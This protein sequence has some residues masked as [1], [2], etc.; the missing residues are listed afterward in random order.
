MRKIFQPTLLLTLLAILFGCSSDDNGDQLDPTE[1]RITGTV[2]ILLQDQTTI[3]LE[4][5]TVELY[6]ADTL[7]MT[8]T[9]DTE[10]DFTFNNLA[11]GLYDLGVNAAAYEDATEE[12]VNVQEGETTMVDI[13]LTALEEPENALRI[14]SG[15]PALSVDEVEWAADNS[16]E[17]GATYS[18][19]VDIANTSNPELYQTERYAND[20]SL[21]YEVA[22]ENGT[23]NLDLHFAEIYFGLPGDGSAGGEGSRV[24]NIDIENG[25]HHID[26]YDIVVAAGG[27]GTAVVESF[28]DINVA[29]GALTIILTSVVENAKISGI[30][31]ITP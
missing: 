21:T 6:A 26:N 9:T 30:V 15:G 19:T 14:N 2:T 12:N 1:G 31:V 13:Q 22:V 25:Q 16:F 7:N 27:S 5:A 4:G 24:F 29:D 3:G 23:Y 28:T 17:D 20:A 11:P 10:G 18:N 8:I